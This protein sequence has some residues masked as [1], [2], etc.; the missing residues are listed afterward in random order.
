MKKLSIFFLGVLLLSGCT[1]SDDAALKSV[2]QDE[3]TDSAFLNEKQYKEWKSV[4]QELILLISDP[5]MLKD[6]VQEELVY[7]TEPEKTIHFSVNNGLKKEQ[8]AVGLFHTPTEW[9]ITGSLNQEQ[10]FR[11]TNQNESVILEYDQRQKTLAVQEFFYILPHHHLELLDNILQLEQYSRLEWRKGQ[12]YWEA[13][14]QSSLVSISEDIHSYLFQDEGKQG[15]INKQLSDFT[16]TYTLS[17]HLTDESFSLE[18]IQFSIEKKGKK[19]NEL[20]F[21]L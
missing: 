21:R 3:L 15:L 14:L 13:S 6:L 2:K 16:I 17:Y 11:M 1:A 9:E 4:Q 20:E 19:V 5:K 10:L 7:W 8:Q 12:E 18:R